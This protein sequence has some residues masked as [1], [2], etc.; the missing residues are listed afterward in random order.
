MPEGNRSDLLA[1]L[2]SAAHPPMGA[3]AKADTQ[4]GAGASTDD[5]A[6]ASAR[7]AA[8]A[9]AQAESG[10]ELAL[11]EL[12]LSVA[13]QQSLFDSARA[14]WGEASRTCLLLACLPFAG[15]RAAE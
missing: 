14:T 11:D 13:L 12:V 5:Q 4:A 10:F 1:Q 6:A 8:A 3:K 9:V 15:S 7:E 2:M